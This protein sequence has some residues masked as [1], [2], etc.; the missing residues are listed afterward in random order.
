MKRSLLLLPLFAACVLVLVLYHA[1][2]LSMA[3]ADTE[4]IEDARSFQVH[5]PITPPLGLSWG[6]LYEH[7]AATLTTEGY[8][9]T[10]IGPCKLPEW[11][12]ERGWQHAIGAWPEFP[13]ATDDLSYY[14]ARVN[15]RYIFDPSQKLRGI[16][17]KCDIPLGA[18]DGSLDLAKCIYRGI[19][20]K[21]GGAILANESMADKGLKWSD[22]YKTK[23]DFVVKYLP[24]KDVARFEINYS[25]QSLRRAR[26]RTDDF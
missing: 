12:G 24:A 20:S 11:R 6:M 9:P 19:Q 13:C 10:E 23:I 14:P 15:A 4:T 22:R 17:L 1:A 21:H 18:R 2:P 5:P 26:G 7:V 25:T 3:A 16:Q 8:K